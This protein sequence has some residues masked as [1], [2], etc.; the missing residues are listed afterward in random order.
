MPIAYVCADNLGRES[1][2]NFVAEPRC[3]GREG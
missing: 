2:G 1:A 3:R